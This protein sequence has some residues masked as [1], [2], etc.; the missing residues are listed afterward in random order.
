MFTAE[1]QTV[2][3]DKSEGSVSPYGRGT[4]EE[5]AAQDRERETIENGR[6]VFFFLLVGRGASSKAGK[7]AA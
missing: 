6:L 2:P 5:R 7:P 1:G 3:K 4:G